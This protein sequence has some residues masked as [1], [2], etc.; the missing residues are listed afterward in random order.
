MAISQDLASTLDLD[1]LLDSIVHAAADVSD[2]SAASI[3]LYDEVKNNLYFQSSTH[4]DTP[5]MKGLSVP[6]EGS[7]AGAI[8]TTRQPIIVS[9]VDQ[10]PRHFQVVAETSKF[11]PRSLLGV[12]LV[13]K[14]KVIGVLEALNKRRGDFTRED[15]TL[16]TAL[17]SQ[18]AIAIQN[19]RLFQQSDLIAEMIHELRTPLAAINTAAYLLMRPEISE[20]QRNNIAK[21]IQSETNR[22]SEMATTFLDLARLESG[23]SHFSIA[24][25][26]L[27]DVLQEAVHLMES[28]MGEQEL[29][30]KWANGKSLPTIQGDRDKI[31]QVVI[32]LLSNAIKYNRPGGFIEI[33]VKKK[34]DMLSFSVKDSGRGILPEH[35][36]G[37]FEKFY[38]VPGSDQVALGTGLGLSISKKIIE[39]HGGTIT[40]ESDVGVGTNFIVSLPL[41]NNS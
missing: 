27:N 21:S 29:T 17:G 33:K 38:R 31:K 14:D 26:D 25:F 34:K 2:A 9:E 16:L 1:V 23:R 20:M 5:L 28:R 11:K 30:L 41:K 10:D 3:L 7:I 15:Q 40:V 4:L 22:L 35:M 19:A 36:S 37:L 18:A 32:N 6:I 8:I 13:A 12:P 39:A 24:D